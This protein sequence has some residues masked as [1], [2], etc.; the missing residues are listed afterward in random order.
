M[1]G[2]RVQDLLKI[3]QNTN[4]TSEKITL[5]ANNASSMYHV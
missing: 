3:I 4:S 5:V 1:Y 2:A